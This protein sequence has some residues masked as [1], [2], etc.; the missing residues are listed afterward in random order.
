MKHL[1]SKPWFGIEFTKLTWKETK[2]MSELYLTHWGREKMAATF[3]RIFFNENVW[4]SI[5]ISLK[6]V[7]EGPINN[8]P[9]LVGI[10]ACRLAGT[11][12]LSDQW[13]L[14]YWRIYESLNL[15]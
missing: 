10:V 7:P 2:D 4:V 8:I 9:A 3:Q 12:P 14:V 1:Q 13:W 6:F 15:D 5:K 11:K